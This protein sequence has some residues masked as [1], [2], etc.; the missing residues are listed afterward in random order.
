MKLMF[1]ISRKGDVHILAE[2][3]TVK[4]KACHETD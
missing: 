4:T 2:E 1:D 3:A